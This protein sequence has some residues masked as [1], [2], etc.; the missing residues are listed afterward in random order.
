VLSELGE[1]RNGWFI[2]FSPSSAGYAIQHLE[3]LGVDLRNSKAAWTRGK[4]GA[5]GETTRKYLEGKGVKVDAVA[6]EPTAQGLLRA[7]RQSD[8]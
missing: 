1:E 4:V 6:E 5:I 2:F 3:R 7:M 8:A